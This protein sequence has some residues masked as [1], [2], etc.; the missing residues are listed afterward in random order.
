[1]TAIHSATYPRLLC[2]I[3]QLAARVGAGEQLELWCFDDETQRRSVE[4]AF[5]SRG[6]SA[7]IRSA[8]K[9]LLHAFLEDMPEIG[10]ASITVTVP[11]HPAAAQ[12]RFRIETYPLAGLIGS[13]A[14]EFRTGT[15][16]LDYELELAAINGSHHA[17]TVFAP[18]A[19]RVDHLGETVLSPCGWIRIG[20]D[21]GTW[22]IDEPIETE[23][24]AVYRD[25]IKSLVSR[26]WG[27][28]PYFDRLLIEVDIPVISRSLQVGDEVMDTAEAMHEEIYFSAL[29]VFQRLAGKPQLSRDI[30]PGQIV[31]LIRATDGD[32]AL[33]MT[34]QPFG[35]DNFTYDDAIE[36]L[37]RA[38]RP[39][40]PGRVASELAALGGEAFEARSVEGRAVGGAYFAG[41]G[42]GIVLTGG[43]HA[44]EATGIVG[45]LRAAHVLK[46][47][48][49]RFA[50]TPLA[51]P[52]GYA[53][54]HR[55]RA[56]HPR[57]MHHA[58]RYTALGDDLAFRN[59]QLAG[60]YE[61]DARLEA[62]RLTQC[63][64]HINLHGYP[65]HEWT[66][67]LTG[68]S[69]RGFG[70]WA[71]PKGFFLI[72]RRNP[73]AAD[74]ARTLIERV[75]RR[76]ADELPDMI[77]F[78][79]EQMRIYRVHT[80]EMPFEVISGIP[81]DIGDAHATNA[82]IE[83]ITEFPDETIYDDA[84]RLGHTCQMQAA[85]AA[86]EI[87]AELVGD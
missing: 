75:A 84:F 52:D 74:L 8:Y 82:S 81:V 4:A 36:P 7:K 35:P 16:A 25:F 79:A 54:Y 67:P 2:G 15:S 80:G 5:A 66:R 14:L 41:E 33:R 71:L 30:Q 43:Q 22:R 1:M 38:G 20:T 29:E 56:D 3:D 24:E 47:A 10:I 6:I 63:Q 68:Y 87:F 85:V 28:Q 37:D 70:A 27:T 78:N 77:A 19:M 86:A 21:A 13:A 64:L 44:N 83:L 17:I 32:A 50:V 48:G 46:A 53:L 57:H 31:P 39:L 40:V 12:A 60:L 45:A 61:L 18:N 51:N 9:P 11:S 62:F 69:P 72:L 23:Y 26:D 55:L 76:L 49:R 73:S 34:I 59:T 58:A 65:A 42:P